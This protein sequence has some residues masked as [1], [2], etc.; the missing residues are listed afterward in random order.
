M[1]PFVGLLA[2]GTATLVI[3]SPSSAAVNQ[4]SGSAF[5][6]SLNV[7][8]FGAAQPPVGPVPTVT[9]PDGGSATPVTATEATGNAKEGPATFF[10]SGP[11]EVS[12]EGTAAGGSV[13][14][15]AKVSTLNTSTQEAFTAASVE[16][17]CTANETGGNGSTTIAGGVLVTDNG[18]DAND[19]GVLDPGD[20]PEVKQDIPA[21]PAPNTSVEGIINVNG[22]QDKFRYVFNEQVVGADGSITVNAIHEF[23]L[24]PTAV[25]DLFV[26][27]SVC[28]TAAAGGGGGGDTGTTTTTVVA[29]VAGGGG[30]ATGGTGLP[31]TGGGSNMPTTGTNVTPLVIIGL[32]LV[33][34]GLLAVFWA[35]RRRV[36]PLR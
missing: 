34:A 8:L 35:T 36:W 27:Q 13:T 28:S 17:T 24:G 18:T 2:L 29:G 20:T 10:S 30:D 23:I 14:S 9:L 16:S 25:G 26:G 33:G 7:S 5:G 6:Y 11:L 1:A 22:S 21:N 19:N 31:A 4:V 12:T 15:K 3:A 32:E